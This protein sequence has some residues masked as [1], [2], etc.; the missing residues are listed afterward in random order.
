M[1]KDGRK[2]ILPVRFKLTQD[3][4][5]KYAPM[6]AD[7]IA[8]RSEDGM[9]AVVQRLKKVIRPDLPSQNKPA[10]AKRDKTKKKPEEGGPERFSHTDQLLREHHLLLLQPADSSPDGSWTDRLADHEAS[11]QGSRAEVHTGMDC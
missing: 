6:L 10:S 7:R 11:Q 1:E 9:D 3:E 2:V 4:M 5:E 8:A